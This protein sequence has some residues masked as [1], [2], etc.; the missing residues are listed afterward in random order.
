V[1]CVQP[2]GLAL[3]DARVTSSKQQVQGEQSPGPAP[4]TACVASKQSRQFMQSPEQ[5]PELCTSWLHGARTMLPQRD[6]ANH[7]ASVN[8]MLPQYHHASAVPP[9]QP[10]E[11]GTPP[12]L[13]G[14][15]AR[16]PLPHRA[17]MALPRY[18]S[19]YFNK[20]LRYLLAGK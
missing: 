18:R 4:V 3:V 15:S 1:Q 13:D 10:R 2:P 8:A 14:A 20:A 9:Q 6:S 5:T 7:S 19:G 17:S 11:R 12:Q 16:L